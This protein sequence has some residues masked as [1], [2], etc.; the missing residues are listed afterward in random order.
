M[1]PGTSTSLFLAGLALLGAG[2]W[3][4]A[5]IPGIL[6][7]AGLATLIISIAGSKPQ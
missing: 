7:L 3:Q 5:H 2:I 4:L 1:K 6:I